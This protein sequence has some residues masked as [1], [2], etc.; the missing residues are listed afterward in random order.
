MVP[1]ALTTEPKPLIVRLH[2]IYCDIPGFFEDADTISARRAVDGID[3]DLLQLRLGSSLEQLCQVRRQWDEQNPG[4]CWERAPTAATSLSLDNLGMPLFDTILVFRDTDLAIEALQFAVI[5]LLLRSAAR[6]ACIAFPPLDLTCLSGATPSSSNTL[7]MPGWGTREQEALET[8]RIV[9]YLLLG[10][11]KARG[12]FALLFPLRVACG[13]LADKPDMV[14]WIKGILDQISHT[15]G[16]Q[17]GEH[18]LNLSPERMIGADL[19]R[20]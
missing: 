3:K 17:I 9:D 10:E 7:L 20:G 13:N 12:A 16:F 11:D 1:W 2:D 19:A 18:V 5:V 15:R 6:T 4:A 8:C 14:R